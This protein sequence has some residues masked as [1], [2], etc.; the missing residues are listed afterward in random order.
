MVID[1]QKRTVAAHIAVPVRVRVLANPRDP[2]VVGLDAGVS[3]RCLPTA[4]G[5]FTEKG[6]GRFSTG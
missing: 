5:T 1:P 6:S 3:P 4:R 2:L